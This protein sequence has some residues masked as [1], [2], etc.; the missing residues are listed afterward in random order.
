LLRI[1]GIRRY[2]HSCHPSMDKILI[3]VPQN[4]VCCL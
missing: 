4:N 1:S 3:T 2:L